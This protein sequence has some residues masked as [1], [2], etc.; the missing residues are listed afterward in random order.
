MTDRTV[1]FTLFFIFMFKKKERSI[2][3]N[4]PTVEKLM[5]TILRPIQYSIQEN[6]SRC[7]NLQETLLHK[8]SQHSTGMD[9]EQNT[10]TKIS[11][12]NNLKLILKQS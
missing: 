2:F 4:V 1:V 11:G 9:L 8:Q 6:T 10:G 12:M 7:K 3:N 5:K